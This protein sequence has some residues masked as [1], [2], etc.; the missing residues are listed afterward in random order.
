MTST[1]K[2]DEAYPQLTFE[3]RESGDL[4]IDLFGPEQRY[5]R[6]YDTGPK[7]IRDQVKVSSVITAH[8]AE[9]NLEI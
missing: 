1:A 2:P 7:H 3:A 5:S 9:P 6:P 8:F 4:K